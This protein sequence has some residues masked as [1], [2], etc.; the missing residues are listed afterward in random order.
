MC[1]DPYVGTRVGGY[2]AGRDSIEETRKRPRT[3]VGGMEAI[4]SV[5]GGGVDRVVG[6]GSDVIYLS[7][8][9]I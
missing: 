2:G 6:S 4:Y 7:F 9:S 5:A 3:R 1:A 8:A